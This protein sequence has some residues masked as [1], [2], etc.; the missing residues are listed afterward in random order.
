MS[1]KSVCRQRKQVCGSDGMVVGRAGTL[2]LCALATHFILSFYRLNVIVVRSLLRL[3][4][5]ARRYNFVSVTRRSIRAESWYF[6]QKAVTV[7]GEY[8]AVIAVQVQTLWPIRVSRYKVDWK[9]VTSQV[10]QN[11]I[12]GTGAIAV[13]AITKLSRKQGQKQKP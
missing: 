8:G 5:T 2:L 3:C 4:L 11:F 6:S 9:E 7:R 13:K 10:T 12:A 1:P